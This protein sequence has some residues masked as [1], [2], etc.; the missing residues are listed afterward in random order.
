MNLPLFWKE[1]VW[2]ST[3]K[4]S[5]PKSFFFKDITKSLESAI[6]FEQFCPSLYSNLLKTQHMCNTYVSHCMSSQTHT[7]QSERQPTSLG[8][9]AR[10]F[11]WRFA[12]TYFGGST[13]TAGVTSPLYTLPPR[14]AGKCR[15]PRTSTPRHSVCLLVHAVALL[16]M[17]SD[18]WWTLQ[19]L[20]HGLNWPRS[21]A[22]LGGTSSSSSGLTVSLCGRP[23]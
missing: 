14:C 19:P 3:F 13:W 4:I 2:L 18:Q 22:T 7:A 11:P 20:Q 6:L 10:E 9:Q 21:R 15:D 8:T 1:H 23:L 12:E 17:L 16:S 5:S